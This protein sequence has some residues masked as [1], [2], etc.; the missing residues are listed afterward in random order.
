MGG[1]DIFLVQKRVEYQGKPVRRTVAAS[2]IVGLDPRSGEILT[3]EIFKWNSSKDTF[4][5][6]GRSYILERIAD[7]KGISIEEANEELERRVKVVEW[8]TE[9]NIRNYKDVSNTIRSYYENS[10]SFLEEVMNNG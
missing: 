9:R 2:E 6:T 7:K 5:Y 4:D 1:I 3:N 10:S 8:M